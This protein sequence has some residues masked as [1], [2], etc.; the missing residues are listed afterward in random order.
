VLAHNAPENWKESWDWYCPRPEIKL[1]LK[2]LIPFIKLKRRQLR[3][4]LVIRDGIEKGKDR[5]SLLP[6]V[7]EMKQLN[8]RGKRR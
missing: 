2:N 4:A 1:F 5:T 7:V 8:Q 6:H 3:L